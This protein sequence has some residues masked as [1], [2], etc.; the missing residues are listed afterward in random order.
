MKAEIPDHEN[1]EKDQK[2]H[3]V[4]RSWGAFTRAFRMPVAVSGEQVTAT[5]TGC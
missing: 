5:T 3:R 4:E 1:E 2:Y